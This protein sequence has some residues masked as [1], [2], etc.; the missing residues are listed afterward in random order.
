MSGY[1]VLR[2]AVTPAPDLP[3]GFQVEVYVN[4]DEMT[5][6]GAGLGMD[7]RQILTPVNRLEAAPEPRTTPF[8]RCDCG[9]YGCGVTD[10]T[11]TRDGDAVHWDWSVELP[12]NRRVSFAADQYDTE[13]TRM[14]ADNSWETPERTA[15]RLVE[16]QADRAALTT[17]GLSFSWAAN[18]HRDP[19]T[20]RV[21]VMLGSDY[22]IFVGTPWRDHTP[23]SLAA[24]VCENLAQGPG[25]WRATWHPVHSGVPGPPPIARPSWRQEQV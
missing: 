24:E 17:H 18:D 16:I 15:A 19:A 7:P 20:F 2:L 23:E 8:A 11:I 10:V 14:A 1:D 9:D 25:R 13:I 22:Q 12:I 21:A 5:S 3:G 4:D 6:A